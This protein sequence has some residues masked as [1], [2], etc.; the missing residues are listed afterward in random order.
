M[1][2]YYRK[3]KQQTQRLEARVGCKLEI[4]SSLVWCGCRVGIGG[5]DEQ[6]KV[7]W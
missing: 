4:K 2:E 6:G 3:C 7:K 5:R 1:K